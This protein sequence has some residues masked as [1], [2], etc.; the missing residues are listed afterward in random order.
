[1]IKV[2]VAGQHHIETWRPVG[3]QRGSHHIP[4]RIEAGRQRASAVQQQASAGPFQSQS[5]T[6][7][8]VEH[9]QGYPLFPPGAPVLR[10]ADHG[11]QRQQ[12]RRGQSQAAGCAGFGASASA[13]ADK[14]G[15]GGGIAQ[16]GRG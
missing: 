13:Q 3:G 4:A 16:R 10:F 2:G 9:A 5:L 15:P 6:L 8:H 7:P 1:M 11:A 14:G 12:E